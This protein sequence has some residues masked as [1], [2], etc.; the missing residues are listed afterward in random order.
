MWYNPVLCVT[1]LGRWVFP[2]DVTRGILEYRGRVTRPVTRGILEYPHS[3]VMREPGVKKKFSFKL[4]MFSISRKKQFKRFKL[5]ISY[6]A[7][8][9]LFVMI[10]FP[11]PFPYFDCPIIT[12]KH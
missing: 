2:V 3:G 12:G 4:V 7:P 8:L 10:G 6:V 1:L 5:E 11:I 9:M